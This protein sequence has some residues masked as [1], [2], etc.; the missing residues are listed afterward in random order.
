MAAIYH[1]IMAVL[2]PNPLK[3]NNGSYK[4]QTITSHTLGIKDICNSLCKKP[5]EG[6]SPETLEYHVRLFLEEMGSL[7][8]DGYSINT[9][10]FT[11]CATIRG[12]FRHKND[13][14]D[15]ER[16]GV[17]YK[18]SQGSILRKRAKE[19]KA[20]ILHGKPVIFGIMK[21]IDTHSGAENDLLSPG[22]VLKIAGLK[23]KL[24]GAHPDIGVYFINEIT[25]ER[26]KVPAEDV[27][28]N[29]NNHLMVVIPDLQSGSYRL[30]Q[31]TQYA[32]KTTPLSVPRRE[33]FVH[34]LRVI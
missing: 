20:E 26:T 32:G 33:T 16:H 22:S 31:I 27:I 3:N 23:L 14:F 21:V 17:S 15:P 8:E 18:F 4:A 13:Q 6:I 34:I 9:G 1:K 7:L 25:G 29:Q 19:T 12:S 30:E 24:T 5:R 2:Y 10:Y 11:A 28:I